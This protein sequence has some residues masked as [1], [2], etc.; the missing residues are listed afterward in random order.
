MVQANVLYNS[1][2]VGLQSPKIE[3]PGEHI[4]PKQWVL[5]GK[6]PKRPPPNLINFSFLFH[7][8]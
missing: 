7:S 6:P 8:D 5:L 2:A 4:S 1:C 3:T